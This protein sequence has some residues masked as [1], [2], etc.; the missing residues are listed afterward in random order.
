[1]NE[2]VN[3][4]TELVVELDGEDRDKLINLKYIYFPLD[5]GEI[6][7]GNLTKADTYRLTANNLHLENMNLIIPLK[8]LKNQKKILLL[9]NRYVLVLNF[10]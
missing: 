6:I 5:D 10:D 4:N 7:T 8:R 2:N 3:K 9:K 1:M